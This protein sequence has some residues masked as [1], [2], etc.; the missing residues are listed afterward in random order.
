MRACDRLSD[1]SGIKLEKAIL[2]LIL[3]IRNKY[4]LHGAP[5]IIL[6]SDVQ[7]MQRDMGQR[8]NLYQHYSLQH[9]EIMVLDFFF[10]STNLDQNSF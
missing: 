8:C 4:L 10:S 2:M 1:H 5:P 9:L 3:E 7:A 6:L